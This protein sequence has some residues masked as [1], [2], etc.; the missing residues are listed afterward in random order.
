MFGKDKTGAAGPAAPARTL[1]PVSER[2]DDGIFDY[3]FIDNPGNSLPRALICVPDLI[4]VYK[5]I[6]FPHTAYN[7]QI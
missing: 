5:Q 4:I 7:R 3:I 2:E 6:G 1:K